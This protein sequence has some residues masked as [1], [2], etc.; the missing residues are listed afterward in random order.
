MKCLLRWTWQITVTLTYKI[1]VSSEL[2]PFLQTKIVWYCLILYNTWREY[3]DLWWKIFKKQMWFLLVPLPC[4]VSDWSNWSAPDA[5]GVRFRVRYM[6]K[7]ALNGGK[8]CPDLIQLGRG[9]FKLKY[10]NDQCDRFS[11]LYNC[12]NL[13]SNYIMALSSVCM[14]N[15]FVRLLKLWSLA[16]NKD[17]Y[18]FD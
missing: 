18:W 7:P 15:L 12:K 4:I 2:L 13:W 5:S 9:K 14:Q 10:L 8:E 11:F 16:L 6:T 3:Y 1:L 17:W